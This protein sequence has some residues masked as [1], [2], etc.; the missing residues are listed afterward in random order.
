MYE[1]D[2]MHIF[3]YQSHRVSKNK[4]TLKNIVINKTYSMKRFN[5][6]KLSK[7]FQQKLKV[8]QNLNNMNLLN[9]LKLY[10]N[11]LKMNY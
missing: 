1:D 7:N 8:L 6:M 11:I 3:L 5:S 9:R 10:T 4:K 2:V